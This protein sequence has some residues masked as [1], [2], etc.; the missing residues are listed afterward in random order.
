MA[1][2]KEKNVI[3]DFHVSLSSIRDLSR[4]CLCLE[5]NVVVPLDNLCTVY[6][7]FPLSVLSDYLSDNDGRPIKAS[8]YCVDL[9]CEGFTFL[10]PVF[11]D[12][13]FN[14]VIGFI[15]LGNI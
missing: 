3:T 6:A 9:D 1:D 2:I 4:D 7:R 10:E 15:D 13:F 12:L 5:S 11:S 14:K 8:V